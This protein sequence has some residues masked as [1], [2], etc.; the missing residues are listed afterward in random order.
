MLEVVR[1]IAAAGGFLVL[2][3]FVLMLAI[4]VIGLWEE[5]NKKW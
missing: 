1:M 5:L 3:L 2:L 4:A